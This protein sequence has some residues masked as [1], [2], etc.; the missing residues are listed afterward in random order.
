MV[1]RSARFLGAALAAFALLAACDRAPA[2]SSPTPA[3]LQTA[4]SCPCHPRLWSTAAHLESSLPNASIKAHLKRSEWKVNYSTTATGAGVFT[5]QL[6]LIGPGGRE[7]I[8]IVQTQ[9]G[10]GGRYIWGSGDWKLA[11]TAQGA[12]YGISVQEQP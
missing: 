1:R 3:P 10:S 5:F 4:S 9:P 8:T 11:V 12:S 2:A 6:Q 7:P